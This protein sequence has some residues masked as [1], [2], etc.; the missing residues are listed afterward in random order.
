LFEKP[1][2]IFVEAAA[3]SIFQ[4]LIFGNML[5]VSVITSQLVGISIDKVSV[6]VFTNQE[7][8]ITLVSSP[9]DVIKNITKINTTIFLNIIQY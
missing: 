1:F 6:S 7:A 2:T 5:W 3:N 9:Q 8:G 4:S